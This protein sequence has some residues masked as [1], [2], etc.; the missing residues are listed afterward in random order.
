MDHDHVSVAAC[1]GSAV[2]WSRHRANPRPDHPQGV[3]GWLTYLRAGILSAIPPG[4][5]VT[6]R[7]DPS[8]RQQEFEGWGTSL[9]WFA[10]IT[11]RYPEPIRQKL[12]D[13]LFGEDGLRLNIA[14]KTPRVMP[15]T[16]LPVG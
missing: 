1:R 9:V 11:G 12:A 4:S 6:V 2:L 14:T 13:M 15:S 3:E 5:A 7:I 8:Y 16:T 10:N